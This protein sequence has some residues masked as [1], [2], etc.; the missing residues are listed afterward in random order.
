MEAKVLSLSDNLATWARE[1]I[2]YAGCKL[3]GQ[4]YL[5]YQAHRYG[6]LWRRDPDH[7]SSADRSFQLD[8]CRAHGLTPDMRFLDFGCGP[9]AAGVHLI[10]YLDPGRYVGADIA[11]SALELGREAVARA[12]LADRD[13]ELVHLPASG[14]LAALEG[15]TFDFV[16]AQ[17]VLTHMSPE[18]ITGLARALTPM[19]T[20]NGACYASFYLARSGARRQAFKDWSYDRAF[21]ARLARTSGLRCDVLDDFNHPRPIVRRNQV[22]AVVRITHRGRL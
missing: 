7:F 8:Y 12:G 16:W 4:T 17:S 21:F 1:G 11:A 22:M 14:S 20:P 10:R 3:R 9:L 15:R 18:S 13:A 5:E 19:L 6:R 2:R